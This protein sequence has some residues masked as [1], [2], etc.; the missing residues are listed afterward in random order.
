[1]IIVVTTPIILQMNKLSKKSTEEYKICRAA[2]SYVE[3]IKSSNQI[4]YGN[5][6]YLLNEIVNQEKNIQIN[7]YKGNIKIM[8]VINKFPMYQ[9]DLLLKDKKNNCV[10]TLSSYINEESIT[11]CYDEFPILEED[12]K[13]E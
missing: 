6:Q 13:S 8:K 5:K 7:S 10:Y 4:S 2:Q 12:I 3:E 1:M 9:L 11:K